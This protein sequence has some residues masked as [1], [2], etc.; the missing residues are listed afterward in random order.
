LINRHSAKV[1]KATALIENRGLA[2]NE[3]AWGFAFHLN[4]SL[5]I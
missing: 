3:P 1:I 2:K 5:E 4:R